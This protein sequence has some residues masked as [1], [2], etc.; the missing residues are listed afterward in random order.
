MA[1]RLGLW[2][3]LWK[4]V[5]WPQIL[6]SFWKVIHLRHRSAQLTFLFWPKQAAPPPLPSFWAIHSPSSMHLAVLWR[7]VRQGIQENRALCIGGV[8]Q[9][10]MAQ[11]GTAALVSPPRP[12]LRSPPPPPM[13]PKIRLLLGK[14]GCSCRASSQS[15]LASL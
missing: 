15:G 4:P 6:R 9:T 10:P 1:L 13:T 2:V 5:S 3:L 14:S 7:G 11:D 8:S 12:P